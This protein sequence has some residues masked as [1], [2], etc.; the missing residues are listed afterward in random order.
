MSRSNSE[1]LKLA[2][3]DAKSILG[4][5]IEQPQKGIVAKSKLNQLI[6]NR[7]IESFER[8][9]LISGSRKPNSEIDSI[10]DHILGKE[11]K[12]RRPILKLKNDSEEFGGKFSQRVAAM[13][14][15]AFSPLSRISTN[16]DD[17]AGIFGKEDDGRDVWQAVVNREH[18][19]VLGD[20]NQN[21]FPPGPSG[22]KLNSSLP[23]FTHKGVTQDLNFRAW[24]ECKENKMATN[25]ANAIV[26]NPGKINPLVIIGASGSGKSHLVQAIAN[27][28]NSRFDGHVRI[29]SEI[30]LQSSELYA[31][32]DI[33][34]L[35]EHSLIGFDGL[36][37]LE[38]SSIDQNQ[39][40]SF[41]DLALNLGV[42]IVLT[43]K[44]QVSE[45]ESSR[46]WELSK[47]AIIA[48]LEMPD[49]TSRVRI[50][51]RLIALN[52]ILLDDSQINR[53]AN[54]SENW[55]DLKSNINLISL[56]LEDGVGVI[57]P[58]DIDSVL[59]GNA[60]IEEDEFTP[61]ETSLQDEAKEIIDAVVD[62]VFDKQAVGGIEIVSDLPELED[63]WEP[64]E[65]DVDSMI[66]EGR[67]LAEKYVKTGL[68]EMIPAPPNV[69]SLDERDKFLIQ[70]KEELEINDLQEVVETMVD[71][72]LNIEDRISD[73]EKQLS[74]DFEL[75]SNLEQKIRE[76]SEIPKDATIEELMAITDSIKEIEDRILGIEIEDN[77]LQEPAE[78]ETQVE[79]EKVVPKE[80]SK[81]KKKVRKPKK[82]KN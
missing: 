39:L 59:Q 61:E 7:T 81:P 35:S 30:E 72:D 33:D 44:F 65:I 48:N 10:A 16:T 60:F 27:G 52:G 64:S 29:F 19:S 8:K 17:E 38:N 49:L 1:K 26:S 50:I 6:G 9:S 3:S 51:R 79:E 46:L 41:I 13:R 73:A 4:E 2:I 57:S 58:S 31:K 18:A 28:F 67:S 56:A 34:L 77:E 78:T 68:D 36:N 24:I 71:F 14:E 82:K 47:D 25:I 69:L 62:V 37:L 53:L 80:P 76:I 42:Q 40:G 11:S 70:R 66:K 54:L 43:T 22:I 45:W 32:I 23:S 55:K 74:Q 63:D 20:L 12:E 15:N 75:I 5:N 21:S